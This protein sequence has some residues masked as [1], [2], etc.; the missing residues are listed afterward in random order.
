MKK[1]LLAVVALMAFALTWGP[2]Y[3]KDYEITKNVGDLAVLI[4]IDKNPPVTGDNKITVAIKDAAGKPVTDASV[5]IDYGMPA[6]P[7]MGAM[8]YKTKTALKGDKY[9]ATLNFSMAGPWYVNIKI[10]RAGKTQ[11]AKLNIDIK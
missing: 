6:M 10:I 8:S 4:T 9:I 5:A 7:G 1:M 11:T 2:V 3:A